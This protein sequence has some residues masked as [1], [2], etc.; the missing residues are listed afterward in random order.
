M[1]K[2]ITLSWIETGY[3]FFAKEGPKGLKIEPIS[4]TVGKNKSSFYHH[5]ADLDIFTEELLKY[6][7][8]QAK[9]ITACIS[10]CKNMVPDLLNI[11]LEAKQDLL[12]NRQLR[13]HRDTPK[14]K[15]CFEYTNQMVEKAI[16]PIWIS[17]LGLEG[18]SYLARI[19]LNL[20]VENF[21][22][23]I[24]ENNLTYDW[25]INYLDSLRIM[26]REMIKNK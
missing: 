25:L 19:I 16:L 18:Q 13:I 11:F 14:F 2:H 20:T 26:T 17:T 24:S 9:D 12:F 6:H 15:K 23:S 5:F 21:Y 8:Q 1:T 22:L 10:S 4:R 3:A 7:L